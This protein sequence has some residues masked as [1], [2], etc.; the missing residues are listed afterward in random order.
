[1]AFKLYAQVLTSITLQLP[2]K[3]QF[4]FAGYIMAKEKGFYKDL[5]LNLKLKEFD[6]TQTND[7]EIR[8]DNIQFGISRSDL[9]VDRL[10][11]KANY[12]LLFSLCQASPVQLQTIKKNGIYNLSDVKGKKFLYFDAPGLYASLDAMLETHHITKNQ[13]Y[14]ITTKNPSIRQITDGTAD[15]LVGYSTITPY[16]LKRL[17][18]N[19]ISFHPK[20]YGFDFY[21]DILYTTDEYAQKNPIIVQNFY[22][23]SLK[24]WEYAFA[25]IEETIDIIKQKYD[26]QQL[27][28]N[29]LEFEANEFKKLAFVKGVP[30]GNIN[31]IKLEK[32]A[33]TFKLL[34]QTSSNIT[35]FNSFIYKPL[36]S[37]K[38]IILNEE[39]ET[40]IKE[41]PIIKVGIKSDFKPIDF[42]DKN[43]LHSG[44][45]NSLL[46]YISQKSGLR[47]TFIHIDTKDLQNALLEKRVDFYIDTKRT[48]NK[49]FIQSKAAFDLQNENFLNNLNKA[50]DDIYF[51]LNYDTIILKNIFDKNLSTLAQEQKEN[52]KRQ[53]LPKVVQTI[54]WTLIWQISSFLAI[55]IIFLLYKNIQQKNSEKQRLKEQVEEKTKD[56]KYTLDEKALLLKE[57][58]H[59]VKNN[60]Q[61]IV[62]L[63]RLQTDKIEDEKIQSSLLT[64]Q[65]RINVMSHLHELLYTQDSVTHIHADD[66]F[67]L[68][69]ENL[70][71]SFN[72]EVKIDYDIHANLNIEQAI[73]VGIIVN[74]LVTNAIKHAFNEQIGYI[75]I[76]LH[77]THNQYTLIVQDNGIGY[78]ELPKN[79]SSLGMNLIKRLVSKQLR[80]E[81][82]L[83]SKNGLKITINWEIH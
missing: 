78:E 56:L 3:Y 9:I 74:E 79:K 38:K 31:A 73:Y 59:R 28:R 46:K 39:E 71:Q 19:P 62:S 76:E 54:D 68:F 69:V 61:M 25:N 55:I 30:F 8:D 23:A 67:E 75:K 45:S 60:M 83:E 72:S 35:D 41:N 57:L 50:I 81:M 24:G 63:I 15:V 80:G 37:I 49:L 43:G 36:G 21:S 2:W 47:F 58:N 13:Y 12:L 11:N 32:I 16:H 5:G 14:W 17:G 27:D 53:W 29:L 22:E 51:T 7:Y 1:M 82:Y 52:I 65:N 48:T 34:G 44:I 10:N 18:F 66:Y 77:Q 6:E 64:I 33:N 70:K 42:I 4:Q 26:T 40:F 20:D